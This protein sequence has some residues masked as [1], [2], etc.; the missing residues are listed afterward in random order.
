MV[1]FQYCGT[2]T[3]TKVDVLH[4]GSNLRRER[5]LDD[6][7]ELPQVK[8]LLRGHNVWREY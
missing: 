6:L 7:E 3:E 1:R 5:Q 4:L 2:L 8:V